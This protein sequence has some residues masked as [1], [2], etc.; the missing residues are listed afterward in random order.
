VSR[1]PY[2]T[3][4][5]KKAPVVKANGAMIYDFT[6]E[7]GAYVYRDLTDD[8]YDVIDRKSVEKCKS[9]IL[10][11]IAHEFRSTSEWEKCREACKQPES[12]FLIAVFLLTQTNDI[13]FFER[14]EKF[15]LGLFT[16]KRP[17]AEQL[18]AREPEALSYPERESV[19]VMGADFA[20]WLEAVRK[21][22]RRRALESYREARD[23]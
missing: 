15:Y 22:Q 10:R 8:K 13:D 3:L 14:D 5:K 9:R 21:N 6:S 11:Y 16:K 12:R 18:S 7:R 17:K 4:M 1:E 19:V 20:H 23:R 2:S